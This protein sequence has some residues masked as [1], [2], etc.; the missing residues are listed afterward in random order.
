[1][2][3]VYTKRLLDRLMAIQGKYYQSFTSIY[4]EEGAEGRVGLLQIIGPDGGNYK[5]QLVNGF[6]KYA[7]PAAEPLHI[8]KITEDTFLSLLTGEIDLSTAFDRGRCKLI[9]YSSGVVDLVEMTKWKRW[10][11]EMKNILNRIVKI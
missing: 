9:E 6:L 1:M 4:E 10:F 7:D 3:E 11:E 8:I 5:L 2:E